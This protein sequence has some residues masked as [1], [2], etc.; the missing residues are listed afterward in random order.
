MH[1]QNVKRGPQVVA[2]ELVVGVGVADQ[3]ADRALGDE[4]PSVDDRRGVARLFDLV[5]EVGGD[6]HGAPLG[7]QVGDQ[8]AELKDA[9]GVEA[10]HRLVQDH[11]LRVGQEAAGDAEPLA[12]ALGV[13]AHPVV[14]AVA[15]PGTLQGRLDPPLGLRSAGSRD[16]PEVLPAAEMRVKARFFDDGPH[17]GQH[18]LAVA[19]EGL[20]GDPDGAGGWLGEADQHPDDGGLAGAVV[21]EEPERAA[22]RHGQAEIRDCGAEAERLVSPRVSMMGGAVV[23]GQASGAV[24]LAGIGRKDGSS[25][26]GTVLSAGSPFA[27]RCVPWWPVNVPHRIA[28]R[29]ETISNLVLALVLAAVLAA[30]T[31]VTAAR[32]DNWPFELAVGAVVCALALFR[33]RNRVWV[34]TAGLVVCSAACLA[35]DVARLPS[36]PGV[37]ATLGLLVLGAAGVRVAA[38]LPAALVAVAGIVVL[39]AGRVTLRGEYIAGFAFLGVLAWGSAL[40]IGMWLRL[41]DIRRHLAIDTARRD[42]RLE[43]A[44]ELHDVVAHHVAGIVVQ[45]QAARIVA[46]KRPGTLDATLAGIESAGN[47][48][49]AA[50]RRVVS[51]L[52]DPG[53]AGGVTPGPEQL[54]ELV[55]RFASHGPAVQLRLPDGHPPPW[56]PEVATT[57]YRIV[58]EALTNVILHAVRAENLVHVMQPGGIR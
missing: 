47:D 35:G 56:P 1:G 48:A 7:H 34:A 53:D 57:V 55:G 37:A 9:G 5:Q 25:L 23:M 38:T 50:M 28:T 54:S 36:Q 40:A 26:V 51:L 14:A 2:G 12:H 58:Q 32:H 10:V 45:A 42:E 39:V 33:G 24:G 3:L 20:A 8:P 17:T 15:E 29:T 46:A 4:A 27:G 52:R 31:M 19:G 22:S 41:L 18:L 13:G 44:R 6:E 30:D 11:Q 49:L 43:L 16:H 21:A